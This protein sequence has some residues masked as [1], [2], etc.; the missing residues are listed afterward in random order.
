MPRLVTITL[1]ALS[2][3]GTGRAHEFW[4]ETDKVR[5]LPGELVKLHLRVGDGFPGE[6]IRRDEK[7][8]ES[9]ACIGSAGESKA[10]PGRSG[11]DPAGYLRARND[12]TSWVAYV[13]HPRPLRLSAKKFEHYLK[14]EGLD[15][16]VKERAR[17]GESEAPGTEL[18]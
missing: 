3:N 17:R 9:F 14:E 1:L 8:I 11:N 15:S 10:V 5:Y 18:Y 12:E 6:V 16:I 4:I 7:H 2:I 13:S